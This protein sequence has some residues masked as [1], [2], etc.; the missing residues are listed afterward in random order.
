M[1]F[2]N[3]TNYTLSLKKG[4]ENIANDYNKDREYLQDFQYIVKEYL[5][6]SN[7]R[8]ILI[9]H[10]PGMGKS[11]LA[12]SISDYYRKHDPKRKI[13]ILLSKSLETNF[14]GNIKK[15][16]KSNPDN[17][18]KEKNKDFINNVLESKYKFISLNSSNMFS[19]ISKIKV[20]EEEIEFNK[21]LGQLN[22][23]LDIEN[24]SN[25]VLENTLLIIDEFHNLSN[26]IKNKSQNAILLYKAIMKTKNIKLIFLTGTPIINN[27]F[28]MVPTFNLLKG[29]LYDGKNKTTL[30]PENLQEFNN[31]FIKKDKDGILSIK[32]K[33]KFQNRIFGLISY[34]G[35]FYF[36]KKG[37]EGFPEQ[38]PII[39]EKVEMSIYQFGR[40]QEVRDIEKKEESNKY[41][42]G[43]DGNNF[44]ITDKSVSSSS[45]RI[46][47]RQ[48][49]NYLIPEYALE[50]KKNRT[51][52][53]KYI[54]KIKDEDLK[55]LDKYSPK[56]KKILE[57]IK[58][59]KNQLGVVY[60]EFVSGEGVAILSK[61]LETVEG[62]KY[63]SESSKL[64]ESLN[65]LDE[66]NL[67]SSMK[68]E[69]RK[70]NSKILNEK[71]YAII[72]GDININDRQNILNI[73]NSDEN[74]NGSLIS[75]LLI[76]KSGAEGLT[77]KNVRHLHI[78]EPF[79]NY[80][81]IDQVIARGS[82]YQS[83]KI[84]DPKDQNIQPYIYIS[85]FPSNYK[86]P[87]KIIEKSTDEELLYASITNKKLIKEFSIA[88]IETSIDC[89][90]HYNNLEKSV[91]ELF[92]CRMCAP[93]SQP[94][95][96]IDIYKDLQ[97]KDSCKPLNEISESKEI[98]AKEIKIL[99]GDNDDKIEHSFYYVQN[100]KDKLDIKLYVFDENIDGY[101]PMKKNYPY[102]SDII[103]KILFP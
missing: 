19:Q 28:E 11:I 90:I 37:K 75:L 31:F 79:W 27:P 97:L 61:I 46:R 92:K 93:T 4:I 26:S 7:N 41:K 20:T 77:L 22:K 16:M 91:Q 87:L 65:N 62:Y 59:Y 58:K 66:Y 80:A 10:T 63:W 43:I 49:S 74:V 86:S 51:S 67:N 55:N 82:R 73:F 13:I 9:Y 21:K 85:I 8:G 1:E 36:D 96:N 56:I 35:D 42:K 64:N 40:Y 69:E 101:I 30:F 29:Y 100:P 44:E 17:D 34:Y 60:S 23:H 15:Y 12:A 54:N 72:T 33:E 45:Y 5:I 38:K 70:N 76:S 95:F 3:N 52:V 94:L 83:H 89:F 48:V 98:E 24:K 81:R 32:N 102:Y 18:D 47:S 68:I 14:K 78:M 88:M 71:N 99:I 57:N 39:I 50:F 84:L 25:N 6:K 103:E 53:I 2:Y